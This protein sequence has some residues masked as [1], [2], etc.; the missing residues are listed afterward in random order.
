MGV[1]GVFRFSA[2]IADLSMLIIT[3]PS[4]IKFR[5]NGVDLQLHRFTSIAIVTQ[6]IKVMVSDG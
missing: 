5:Q 3:T 4:E 6:A 2:F 1:M